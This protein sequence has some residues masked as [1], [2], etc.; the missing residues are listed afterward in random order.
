MN[1]AIE[2][3]IAKGCRYLLDQQDGAG[4][5]PA[6]ESLDGTPEP[7]PW[8]TGYLAKA[9]WFVISTR[10][11]DLG[12]ESAV[13]AAQD[14][15]ARHQR[16]NGGWGATSNASTDA[17]TTAWALWSLLDEPGRA[18]YS[19][20]QARRYLRAHWDPGSGGF[21]PW[22]PGVDD[23]VAG[24]VPESPVA[25]LSEPDP[26]LTAVAVRGLLEQPDDPMIRAACDY[27]KDAQ[28][29][30]G[31][32]RSRLWGVT[33]CATLTALGA[34][35]V[36]ETLDEATLSAARHGLGVLLEDANDYELASG[37]MTAPR[38]GLAN[39]ENGLERLLARQGED[40]AWSPPSP[41]RL[42]A[43]GAVRHSPEGAGGEGSTGSST[44]ADRLLTTAAAVSALGLH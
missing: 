31:L 27:L 3:A 19:T 44:Y 6:G 12:L 10:E 11:R 29:P 21:R 7:S 33:G 23:D 22:V 40:G 5:W 4:M 26:C 14:N 8:I 25:A 9:L 17:D 39:V 16:A 41:V 34:L 43:A 18:L 35:F 20:N 32:W 38:L 37:L 36:A 15:L 24:E 2:N 42:G 28:D 30:D 1:E 13:E